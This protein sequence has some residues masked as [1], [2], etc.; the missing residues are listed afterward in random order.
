[1][2]LTIF[3]SDHKIELITGC[4]STGTQTKIYKSYVSLYSVKTEPQ[5][6]M[7]KEIYIYCPWKN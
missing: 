2:V 7:L 6:K 4:K 3:P 1:M 5:S